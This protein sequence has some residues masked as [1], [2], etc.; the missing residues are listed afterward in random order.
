MI[1]SDPSGDG[2]EVIKFVGTYDPLI[3][4][5]SKLLPVVVSI[6]ICAVTAS[7]EKSAKSASDAIGVRRSAL[8]VPPLG[9]ASKIPEKTVPQGNAMVSEYKRTRARTSSTNGVVVAGVARAGSVFFPA[10]RGTT[11]ALREESMLAPPIAN[12]DCGKISVDGGAG[13]CRGLPNRAATSNAAV[14]AR[15]P[16]ETD[17]APMQTRSASARGLEK[18]IPTGIYVA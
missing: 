18:N 10:R 12:I 7:G 17:A 2:F 5:D 3:D 9:E 8:R 1:A 16:H 15:G 4:D 13:A 6:R 14:D 11:R